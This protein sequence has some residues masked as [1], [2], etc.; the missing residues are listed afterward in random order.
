MCFR[1]RML[2]GICDSM[3]PKTATHNIN[4]AAGW[5][6]RWRKASSLFLLWNR[7]AFTDTKSRHSDGAD[8]QTQNNQ[9]QLPA[10][11]WTCLCG[12]QCQNRG[13]GPLE[14][15]AKVVAQCHF[16]PVSY[17]LQNLSLQ[18]KREARDPWISLTSIF[19]IMEHHLFQSLG[20]VQNEISIERK[21]FLIILQ[22][23]WATR[24]VCNLGAGTSWSL[25]GNS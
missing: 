6:D 1:S 17:A 19:F 3:C 4:T 9:P 20:S 18:N 16:S 11:F 25:G 12:L 5:G 10:A 21:K 7:N 24:S 15:S 2:P 8:K 22:W 14:V 13:R 23:I